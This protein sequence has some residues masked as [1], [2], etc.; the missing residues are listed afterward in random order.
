[1][2]QKTTKPKVADEKSSEAATSNPSSGSTTTRK[3]RK[4]STKK[5]PTTST[6]PPAP[7]SLKPGFPI[8]GIG[9]SAGGLEALDELLGNMPA[10]TGMAFVVVTHQHPSHTSLLPEL[11]GK[12]TK[13]Q[14]IEAADG[15][16]L[17]AN[18]VYVGPPGGYLAILNGILH[19][20]E[21]GKKESPRLPIDY[22]FRSLAEDQK[23]RAIGIVLP[24]TGTDGTLGVNA[25]K[26]ES[27]MVMVQQPQSAKYAGMPSSAIA[28]GL[29][30][31]VLPQASM[32]KQLIAYAK[33]PYL[34]AAAVA[35]EIPPVPEEPMQRIFVL[36]RSRT[37][38]DFSSYKSNT[39]RRRIERRMN[40]HQIRNPNQ[41]VRYLQENAHE[42]THLSRQ[43]RD[44][45]HDGCSAED[46]CERPAGLDLLRC[47]QRQA[48][49]QPR[50]VPGQVEE[51]L[52]SRRLSRNCGRREINESTRSVLR[53]TPR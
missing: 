22:F 51:R 37:G 38:H 34:T 29:A 35:A 52:M 42:N 24:A 27:G 33:G 39:L 32:P 3:A 46:R 1:M 12:E 7:G 13:M 18:H 36:L 49:G 40:V 23:E 5:T 25:V 50:R 9:A 45:R 48:V 21:T 31:Y 53:S 4:R 30:D 14:V 8:V 28:T 10:D 15:T 11:L 43:W 16:Q 19:R 41:Y 17:E 47:L 44:A 2:A 26:G 6:L 20:M